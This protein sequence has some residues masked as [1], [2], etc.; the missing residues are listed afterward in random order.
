M[1][2]NSLWDAV[3]QFLRQV[4][5]VCDAY[6]LPL[7][8]ADWSPIKISSWIGGDRDGNPNVTAGVTREVL[9]LAQWQACE[10]FSAD[11]AQLHEELSATT[12]TASFKSSA[13]DAREPYRA[14]LKP[15]LVTLRGQRQALEAALNQ[16]APTPAPLVL[17]VLLAPLQACFESLIASA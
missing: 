8:S 13:M 11:V 6:S 4:D 16:G 15:L 17:D 12:A 10:L 9:L 14:V 5:A 2:E 3:P 1:I 7:P